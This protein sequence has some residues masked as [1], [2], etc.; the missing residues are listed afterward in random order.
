MRQTL[1]LSESLYARLQT[2]AQEDGADS[3]EEFIRQ[4]VEIWESCRDEVRR[5]QE[6]VRRIDALRASLQARYG[7]MAD[8]V[9]WIREDRER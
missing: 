4:L 1:T 8:S 6:V 5:R 7:D 9:A 2:A 3:L